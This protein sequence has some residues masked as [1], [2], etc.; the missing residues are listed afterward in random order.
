VTLDQGDIETYSQNTSSPKAD[1]NQFAAD[2]A[3]PLG[4]MLLVCKGSPLIPTTNGGMRRSAN[5]S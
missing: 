3:D 1:V 5:N 2:L 4:E